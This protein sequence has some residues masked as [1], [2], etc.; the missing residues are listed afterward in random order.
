M[1][2]G[3]ARGATGNFHEAGFYHSDAEFLALIQPFVTE[4]LAAGEPVIIGYDE[5]KCDLLRAT[6]RCPERVTFITDTSL[7]AS[8]ARAIEAYRQ[9]FERHVA[10][11]AEQIRIAGDV[12]H[13]GNGGRFAGWD[14]YESAVNAV[15][16]AYPVWSRCL[17]D[18][19]TTHDDVR[20]VV[21]RTHRRLVTPD[22][23][24]TASPHYQDVAEFVGLPSTA[25]PLEATPPSVC[26]GDASLKRTRRR[27]AEAARGCLDTATLD[28]FVFALSE[29][30]INAQSYGHPPVGVR[31]WTAPNRVVVRVH[32]TGPG[33]PDPLTGLVPVPESASGAGLGLWLSHQLR[34]VEVDLITDAEGFTVRL[35]AGSP[36]PAVD[37]VGSCALRAGTLHGAPPD[38]GTVHA[39]DGDGSSLCEVVDAADLRPLDDLR[40]PDLPAVQQCPGCR[41]VI[42]V[43]DGSPGR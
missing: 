38:G 5:R 31:V 33:P 35:R 16:Q 6:L 11:G 30:V 40:W 13:E 41:L 25:D 24:A 19:T 20:D 29:A 26:L 17:Y 15:W 9:Q 43:D 37:A 18:A 12:P 10:A 1:R 27:V 22:G 4:G 39:I 34:E 36:P 8:P 3:P 2:T 42:V 21:V 28:E 7:Y 23:A 32:D 14:R